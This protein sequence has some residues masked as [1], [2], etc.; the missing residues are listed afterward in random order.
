MILASDGCGH[1]Y[2]RI[3][4]Q[5]GW[6]ENLVDHIEATINNSNPNSGFTEKE[7]KQIGVSINKLRVSDLKTILR[8]IELTLVNKSCLIEPILNSESIGV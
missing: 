5:K 8:E 2:C 7:H 3:N 6:I 4:I 1:I